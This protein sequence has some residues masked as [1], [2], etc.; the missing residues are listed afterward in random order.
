[1]KK[2]ILLAIMYTFLTKASAQTST[3]IIKK[4]TV[5]LELLGSSPLYYNLTYDRLLID[6]HDMRFS[7]A[8]GIQYIFNREL[9]GVLNSD[10]SMTPQF[11]ILFGKR[12]YFEFGIG[13][14]FPFGPDHEALF[15]IRIGYRFQKD[16]GGLFFKAAFTPIHFPGHSFF[17]SPFL[18]SGGICVGHSF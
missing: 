11:N 5:Y 7:A 17:G 16:E 15:P 6:E 13:A 9:D 10:F 1:M 8:V 2:Y 4:N 3:D 14:A 12:H 18:P